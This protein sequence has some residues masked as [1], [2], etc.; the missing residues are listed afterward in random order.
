MLDER[1]FAI[2]LGQVIIVQFRTEGGGWE[3]SL[4]QYTKQYLSCIVIDESRYNSKIFMLDPDGWVRVNKYWMTSAIF[5]NTIGSW[6][7]SQGYEN[8]KWWIRYF[9]ILSYDLF[10]YCRTIFLNA[11]RSFRV[12]QGSVNIRWWIWYLWIWS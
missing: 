4:N 2:Q 7:M 8:I 3:T 11:F 12:I 10:V 9:W 1:S 6:W 5:V